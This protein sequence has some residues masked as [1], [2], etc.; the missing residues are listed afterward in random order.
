MTQAWLSTYN[1]VCTVEWERQREGEKERERDDWIGKERQY[2]VSHWSD[3]SHVQSRGWSACSPGTSLSTS[4]S[5]PRSV[6][7]SFPPSIP[8][9][10]TPSVSLFPSLPSPFPSLPP[11]PSHR[12]KPTL[13]WT[14]FDPKE[15]LKELRLFSWPAEVWEE[16]LEK[17]D[18]GHGYMD[19]PC[20]NPADPDC[21]LSAPNKN[22]TKVRPFARRASVLRAGVVPPWVYS[23]VRVC[24]SA[25]RHSSRAHRRLLRTLQEVHALAGGADRG[26][27][28]QERQRAPPQ[29]GVGRGGGGAG[30]GGGGRLF[31][32]QERSSSP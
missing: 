22:T 13:Q 24:V 28:H 5:I 30:G 12:G 31:T 10:L 19:R 21:P 9:S 26:R 27:G 14:N 2:F 15:L 20:L 16:M 25:L 1:V 7:L 8:S 6:L 32:G 17:A 3:Y 18:V 4:F 29:V 11:P 23:R